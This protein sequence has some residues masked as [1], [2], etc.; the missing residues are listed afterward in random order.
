MNNILQYK[1]YFG[2][3]EISL[4]DNIMYGTLLYV[5][6]LVTYEASS[7][8][9]LK[10]SF[11]DAVDEYL[12]YCQKCGKEPEKPF[13]G[14][15]N[16]RITPELHRTAATKAVEQ[17]IS[18]NQFVSNAIESH[19]FEKNTDTAIVYYMLPSSFADSNK[20]KKSISTI[21]EENS[22]VRQN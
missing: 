17:G 13:K 18:L 8:E 6:D 22:Y 2:N 14:V 12:D 20:F 10:K 3:I 4:D 11:E 16:I 19:C 1:G 15:F 7:V 21:V 5:N 9:E